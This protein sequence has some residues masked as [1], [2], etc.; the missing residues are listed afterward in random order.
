[1]T[2]Y[3]SSKKKKKKKKSSRQSYGKTYTQEYGKNG[4]DTYKHR[5][6]IYRN[7]VR[8]YVYWT[9]VGKPRYRITG[10]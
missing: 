4:I 9:Y 6:N 8:K 2:G 3:V 5:N 7:Q 1:M 10:R